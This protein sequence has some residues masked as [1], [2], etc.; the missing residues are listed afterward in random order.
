MRTVTLP[1]KPGTLCPFTGKATAACRR[2]PRCRRCHRALAFNER[3]TCHRC[4]AANGASG[5]RL[6]GGK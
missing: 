3:H 1:A 2:V 5:R 4:L 6:G